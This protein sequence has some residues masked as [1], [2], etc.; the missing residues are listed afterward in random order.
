MAEELTFTVRLTSHE[1]ADLLGLLKRSIQANEEETK[2]AE[3]ELKRARNEEEKKD[4]L[5]W[6]ECCLDFITT[7]KAILGK[8]TTILDGGA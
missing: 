4:A 8:V 6:I 2:L 5:E 1:M 3:K 7:E